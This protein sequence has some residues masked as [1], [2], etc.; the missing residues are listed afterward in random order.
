[1]IAATAAAVLLFHGGD[2]VWDNQIAIVGV[3][4][5]LAAVAAGKSAWISVPALAIAWAY[6]SI[7]SLEYP[8]VFATSIVGNA[9]LVVAIWLAGL[10][11]GRRR[12]QI[13]KLE[14]AKESAHR[15][16]H[17]ERS[18]LAYE[19]HDVIGHSITI[20]VLQAAGAR[21]IM[22]L[23]PER[24]RSALDPIEE[25]GAEAMRELEQLLALLRHRGNDL[26]DQSA[27]LLH[28]VTEVENL[29]DRAR[30]SL[31]NVNLEAIGIPHHL[32]PS[33]DLAAYCVAREGLTNAVKHGDPQS[34]IDITV[35]WLPTL[36]RVKV[37]SGQASQ[38]SPPPPGLS[39]GFGLV[40]LRE[41]VTTAGGELRWWPSA[42]RFTVE[43]RFPE[44]TTRD[45]RH[46]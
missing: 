46:P 24:A 27:D 16:L 29:V 32:E 19:L 15:T 43:A 33:V 45:P 23:N 40:S 8:Y 28:G 9:A 31:V 11:T 1:V 7:P 22:E 37:T 26:P 17:Q 3:A 34:H 4:V 5:A 35:T 6:L 2:F 36:L 41:R 13:A 44:P 12:Q 10:V 30:Q 21:R 38:Q 39:G 14:E 42:D 25:S 20:M 18:R